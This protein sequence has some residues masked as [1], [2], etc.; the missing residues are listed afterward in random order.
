MANKFLVIGSAS[1]HTYNFIELLRE[2]FDEVALVTSSE[3]KET[4]YPSF[5]LDF[6]FGLGLLRTVLQLKKIG[7]TF[8]PSVVHVHQSNN[9]ALAAVLAFHAAG[10]PIILTA[11]GSDV[12][13]NPYRNRF[14]G[15]MIPFILRRVDAVTADSDHVLSEATRLA[16]KKLEM[17]N[18]NF[19]IDIDPC[20]LT[21]E[22]IVYSNRLHK[23]LYNI[24]KILVSFAAFHQNRPEWKLI[25]AGSG[26]ETEAL[27]ELAR[28]LGIDHCTD[29]IG[30]VDAAT[31]RE[32]YCRSRIY[33]SVPQS[34][35]ISLSLVEAIAYGCIPFVSDLPANRELITDG[36]N[37]F[38]EKE[39]EHIDFT[40]F[41]TID[42]A[43]LTEERERLIRNFSKD[44]NRQRYLDL[45]E[46][47]IAP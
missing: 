34:D 37:G 47:Y 28:K 38:I 20:T 45:Y 41:A 13:I 12:L 3:G 2:G 32:C 17:H 22:P 18:I 11:W 8:R 27:R 35:S 36:V 31:N 46:R 5:R 10:V 19:G 26:G 39:P 33:V 21:K 44:V 42:T 14:F 7:K 15:W 29:F 24:D 4:N 30:F 1:I 6:S 43:F 23:E 16:G 9:Y 40:K 25:V